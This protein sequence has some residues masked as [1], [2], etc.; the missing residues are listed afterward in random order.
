MQH[1]IINATLL[2]KPPLRQKTP[3]N[4]TVFHCRWGRADEIALLK[5]KLHKCGRAGIL[6]KQ[7]KKIKQNNRMYDTF[8]EIQKNTWMNFTFKVP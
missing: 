8:P 1:T 7:L 4:N 6:S 5:T 2:V 3:K